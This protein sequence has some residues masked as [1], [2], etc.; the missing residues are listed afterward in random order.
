MNNTTTLRRS[1][2]EALWEEYEFLEGKDSS[3][4]SL[5]HVIDR[6][7]QCLCK[8]VEVMKRDEDYELGV[9]V[10][11]LEDIMEA[12]AEAVIDRYTLQD[13]E[14]SN[15][16]TIRITLPVFR[17][18]AGVIISYYKGSRKIDNAHKIKFVVE[19]TIGVNKNGDKI[20]SRADLVTAYPI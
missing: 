4:E 1:L 6:H 13:I 19:C 15:K 12:F 14:L 17:E 10:I 5:A 9:F 11:K 16:A 2:Y 20:V 8:S 3:Y 7:C 18:N